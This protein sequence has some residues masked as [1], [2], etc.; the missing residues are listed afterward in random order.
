MLN[1]K[2]IHAALADRNM[3][4]VRRQTGLGLSTLLKM[5]AGKFDRIVSS[6]VQIVSEYL[7]SQGIRDKAE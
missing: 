4:E 3:S 2:T 1:T 5:K 7:E 6:R